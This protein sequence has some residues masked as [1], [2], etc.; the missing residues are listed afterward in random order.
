MGT[1]AGQPMAA[2]L[3]RAATLSGDGAAG[4]RGR[5][6]LSRDG[7]P[8][9]GSS[10]RRRAEPQRGWS[11]VRGAGAGEQER[12][13]WG[14]GASPDR[15]LVLQPDWGAAS[16]Q[17]SRA[18]GALLRAPSPGS[19]SWA[20]P[21]AVQAVMGL[22]EPPPAPQQLPPARRVK[23]GDGVSLGPGPMRSGCSAALGTARTAGWPL[24]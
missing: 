21:R 23:E 3:C 17:W 7:G 5:P 13:S 10:C 1:T 18:G 4:A 12:H 15:T 20:V 11:K 14:G 16:G 9:V 24:R 19:E 8:W 6:A 22:C 2:L